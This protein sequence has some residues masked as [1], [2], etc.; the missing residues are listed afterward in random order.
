M[1]W[2][3]AFLDINVNLRS[4][5]KISCHWYQQ[6][7]DTG[8]IQNFCSCALLH[9]KKN[10]IQGRARRVFNS[11]YNWLAFDQNL[12]KNKT[13]WTKNQHPDEWSSKEV[14]KTLKN[15]KWQ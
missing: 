4:K 15:N 11:L 6:P 5:N 8:K 10:V 3:G 7:N 13:C 2:D 1:E 14:N 9:Y 12:Q